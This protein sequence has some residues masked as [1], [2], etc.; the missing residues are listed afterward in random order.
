MKQSCT[1]TGMGATETRGRFLSIFVDCGPTPEVT[2]LRFCE[3]LASTP[4]IHRSEPAESGGVLSETVSTVGNSLANNWM[5]LFGELFSDEGG[6]EPSGLIA[7]HMVS[8]QVGMPV[9]EPA[10]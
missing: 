9:A 5:L 8:R 2:S 6:Q 3:S 1:K 7:D 10:G 4:L